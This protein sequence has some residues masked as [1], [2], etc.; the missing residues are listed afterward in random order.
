VTQ[1]QRPQTASGVT[2]I[3]LEDEHGPI[4]VIVWR[5]VAERQ[6]RVFLEARLLGVDGRWEHVDGVS[7]LIAHH[8][9]DMS[10]LLGSL[11]SRSRDFH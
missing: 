11:D 8:L 1:R 5:Q 4:N 10:N 3:T 6:R 7:H 9:I 2:F